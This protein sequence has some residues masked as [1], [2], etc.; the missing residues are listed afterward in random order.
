MMFILFGCLM[1]YAA[2]PATASCSLEMIPKSVVV[3]FGGSLSA[4]CKS[5]SGGVTGMGWESPYG[6]TGLVNGVSNLTLQIDSLKHW[7]VE[8][9]CFVN[10]NGSQCTE[11]L[12]V[13]VY[14]MPDSVSISLFGSDGLIVEGETYQVRCE[15]SEVA[16]VRDV[17][18]ELLYGNETL[19]RDKVYTVFKDDPV[20]FSFEFLM[21]SKRDYNGNRIRCAAKMDFGP[22][23]PNLPVTYSEPLELTVQYPPTFSQPEDETLTLPVGSWM[24]LNCS[25]SG[26]PAPEYSWNIPSE[27]GKLTGTGDVFNSSFKYPGTYECTAANSQGAATKRFTVNG[28]SRSRPGTTAGI[29]IALFFI[30]VFVVGCG[31]YLGRKISRRAQTQSQNS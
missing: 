11:V 27:S 18:M 22:S 31:V 5:S 12:P 8:P 2:K 28:S 13:T 16:P 30:V 19:E 24:S 14:K 23:G 17:T 20:T 10:V 7:S 6:G 25:A 15:A 3:P 21:L 26:N 9:I 4:V 1:A 29:L